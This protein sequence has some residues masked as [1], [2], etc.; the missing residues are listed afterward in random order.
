MISSTSDLNQGLEFDHWFIERIA[1]FCDRKSDSLV[2]K[3]YSVEHLV[4]NYLF[5]T[6]TVKLGSWLNGPQWVIWYICTLC[7]PHSGS[8]NLVRC[9]TLHSMKRVK[10]AQTTFV[11]FLLDIF[12]L[13]FFSIYSPP[14]LVTLPTLLCHTC[15][16]YNS[17]WWLK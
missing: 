4:S 10:L 13:G 1:R 7:N 14:P 5:Y 8:N 11:F 6:N 9:H 12:T 3:A 2:K 17:L 15:T 16:M